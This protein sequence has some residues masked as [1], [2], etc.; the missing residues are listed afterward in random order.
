VKKNIAA[1]LGLSDTVFASWLHSIVSIRNVCAHHERLWNR[2]LRIQPLFPRKTKHTWLTDK[3]IPNNRIYYVLS[4]MIYFLNTVN[5]SHTFK[6]KLENLFKKYP[7]VDKKAMGFP[8]DW[9]TEP[10]WK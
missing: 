10:L 3:N 8:K 7:N 1:T 2:K 5:P 4:M 9:Q 6:Q